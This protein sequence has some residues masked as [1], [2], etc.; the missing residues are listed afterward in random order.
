[1]RSFPLPAAA[2]RQGQGR[3]RGANDPLTKGHTEGQRIG[4]RKVTQTLCCYLESLQEPSWLYQLLPTPP[5]PGRRFLTDSRVLCSISSGSFPKFLLHDSL[6]LFLIRGNG[7]AAPSARERERKVSFPVLLLG[8]AAAAARPLAAASRR[9]SPDRPHPQRG[10]E[11]GFGARSGSTRAREGRKVQRPARDVPCPSTEGKLKILPSLQLYQGLTR[12]RSLSLS[13]EITA[14][15]PGAGCSA[16][17]G[18]RSAARSPAAAHGG[19]ASPGQRA[20]DAPGARRRGPAAACSS[21]GGRIPAPAA[22]SRPGSDS[23]LHT[24][25]VSPADSDTGRVS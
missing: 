4:D 18:A 21:R 19:C 10:F 5:P 6:W 16:G 25:A 7:N 11:V 2:R 17:F 9:S 3:C 22:A 8:F 1:M 24:S 12:P 14:S 13:P 23:A 20:R 15:H